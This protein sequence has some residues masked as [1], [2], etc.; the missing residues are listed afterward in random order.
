VVRSGRTGWYY[1]V[2]GE[3]HVRPGVP[4]TL[5]ERP[6]PR[7]SIARVNAVAYGKGGAEESAALAACPLLSPSWREA[8]SL[9]GR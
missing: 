3:G 6:F 9:P 1:R 7:W 5:V 2:L 4:V 8:L